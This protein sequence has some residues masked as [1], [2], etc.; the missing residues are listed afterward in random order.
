VASTACDCH[1]R[2]EVCAL[3]ALSA[4]RGWHRRLAKLWPTNDEP[5]TSLAIGEALGACQLTNPTP[6]PYTGT[7]QAKV[8]SQSQ[9]RCIQGTNAA[10]PSVLSQKCVHIVAGL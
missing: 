9:E 10:S 2:G 3:C 1:V 6:V 7:M 8:F 4:L 5:T